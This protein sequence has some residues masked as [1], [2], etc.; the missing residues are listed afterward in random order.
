MISLIRYARIV[1]IDNCAIHGVTKEGQIQ[2]GCGAVW[3]QYKREQFIEAIERAQEKIE[4]YLGYPLGRKAVC[5]QQLPYNPR[6]GLVGPTEWL[7]LLAIGVDTVTDIETVVLALGADPAFNDPVTFTVVTTVTDPCEIRVFHTDANGGEEIETSKVTITAGVAT[8]E[9]PRCHLID[10]D[11]IQPTTV[12][13]SYVD[14]S[15][16]VTTVEVRRVYTDGT[17]GVSLVYEPCGYCDC[18]GSGTPCAN[19]LQEACGVI[20]DA[21]TGIVL[22]KPASYSAGAWSNQSFLAGRVPYAV[23]ISYVAGFNDPC[24]AA[25]NQMPKSLETSIFRLAHTE[26]PQAVCSC[27]IHA[28]TWENDRKEPEN[29]AWDVLRNPFGTREGQIY[30]YK[31]LQLYSIQIGGAF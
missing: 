8:I 7:K 4:K 2:Y 28:E 14:N 26:M 30:A 3:E 13:F 22:V 27:N 31:T 20:R 29:I 5:D 19:T 25:C 17:T 24:S 18:C 21:E 23:Q 11:E 12:G 1:G 6:T 16:F 10:T 9:I 15:L